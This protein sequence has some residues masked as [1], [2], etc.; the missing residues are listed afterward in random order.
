MTTETIEP[1]K[2]G[3]SL[4]NASQLYLFLSQINRMIMKVADEETLFKEACCI[5][6]NSGK[7]TMAWIGLLDEETKKLVPVAYAG[8][9]RNYLSTIKIAAADN[10]PEGRGPTGRALR[11][12]KYIFCNNI[13]TDPEMAPWKKEAINRGYLSSI[14]LPI[15]KSGKVIGSFSL[16]APVVNF[17]NK[18][19]IELLE[20]T[21]ADISF[22]L[23]VFKEE[24]LRKKAEDELLKSQ[25][26]YQTLTESSPVGIFHTDASGYTTYVNPRWCK[27]SGMCAD[28]A[29]GNGWLNAVHTE[30][31][32]ALIRG[33]EQATTIQNLSISEYRFMRSDGTVAWVLGQAVPERNIE[34]DIV[35]YI[36]T[37]TDITERKKS[38]EKIA[39]IYK[40]KQ[41]ALNRINDGMVSVDNDWR[42][43]FLNDAALSTHPLE[44]EQVL[45][46][47]IWDIHP[48][49]KSTIFW[50]KYHEAMETKQPVE[51]E[52]SYPAMH[53]WFSVKVYP[54]QDGL[55]IFYKDISN[56]K[57]TEAIL[58]KNEIRLRKAQEIGKMGYWEQE[59]DGDM[60]WASK[61]AKW[62]YGFPPTE[63][64]IALKKITSCVIDWQIVKTAFTDLI[65]H[66]K[67]YK[68]EFRIY[69]ADGTAIKYISALAE[70]ER[71]EKGEPVRI[72]GTL[73]DIT[74]RINAQN[75]I[76]KEKNLSDSII[77]CLPGAF[78]LY[79]RKGKFLRWNRN[80][81]EVTMFEPEEIRHMH[82]LDFF[83]TNEKELIA[84]KIANTFNSGE[85][86]VLADLLSKTKEKIPYYFTGT[87]I[88]YEGETC[89]MGVGLDF[90][91]RTRAQQKI[92]ETTEQLRH[93]TTHLQTVREEER[94][95][96]GR[97]IHD[98]LGQQLTA[99]KMDI[100]WIDKKIPEETVLLKSK[101]KNVI[102]LLDGSNKSIRRI[103]SEL[104]PGI[105]D[106]RG[107][108]DAIEW[109]GR[110]LTANAGI[111]VQF[112]SN[113]SDIK[114]PEQ[115]STCIF[116]V[117]QEALT[118]IIRYANAGKVL[119]SLRIAGD[120]IE[121]SIAD[122]GKGFDPNSVQSDKSFG[123]L[124][125]KERVHSLGGKFELTSSVGKGTK[126]SISLPV[127][128]Q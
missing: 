92:K 2:A 107:L 39:E 71:N 121:V 52:S 125:M 7:F 41:T 8:N 81:E 56:S 1:I 93:L 22:A 32:E 78:Y 123:I 20:E 58:I 79:N 16:Y 105:L 122:D 95:R 51:F 67:E 15:K 26:R 4:T 44:K 69:P 82:P 94:K 9:E 72:V 43:T 119:T 91:E 128:L 48:E 19:E 42:F 6:V 62:I 127:F 55:T 100:A 50:D 53:T 28:D 54:S 76:I 99:I 124:G 118:N 110:Q 109:L 3:Q 126:I 33:W 108:L 65:E 61:A 73:Q 89:L 64:E 37:I 23:E 86:S 5:A 98:E 10:V 27:I 14:A 63:G 97:E 21:T 35:G 90:S 84:Q 104:R 74:E 85:D 102:G 112:T 75:E 30:D 18:E 101:L 59:L 87:T 120:N 57:K 70:L 34:N 117:Y 49:M 66:N 31:K 116:R 60:V 115:I 96:I 29:L 40:E 47:V 83:D 103:L 88:E 36:G 68:I 80:F 114:L 13:E 111:P 113:E 24:K 45:G 11:D 17:F 106:D 46:K 12:G 77:N 38:E 25:L